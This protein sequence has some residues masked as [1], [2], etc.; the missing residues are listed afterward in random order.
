MSRLTDSALLLGAGILLASC[1]DSARVAGNSANTGNAQAA[2]R[3]VGPEGAPAPG[4]WIECRPDSL[5][6]WE[7]TQPGWSTL[8]DSSGSYLCSDLPAGRVGIAARDL[9]SG[10]TSWSADTAQVASSPKAKAPDT[11]APSGTLR[12]AL[13]PGSV[14]IL[15]LS[16]LGRSYAVRG[17]NE[18]ELSDIP[19]RWQ[20]SLFLA[21]SSSR[22]S[23][24]DSGLRVA[25]GRTDSAGYT[26]RSMT[27]RVSLGGKLASP[28]LQ[29]PLLARLD[30][31]WT[32][33]DQSLPDGSDLR[34]AT[35]SGRSLPTTVASWDRLART[36]AIWT[37][38]D[39]VAAPG[40]SVD[41]VLS[42]G[43]PVPASAPS[44][45]FSAAR[46]W[47]AA[48]PLG[49]TGAT[50]LERLGTF[51]GEA[52]STVSAPGPI[53]RS[54]RFDG[55]RSHVR[56]PGSATGALAPPDAGPY[57]WS[58]WVRLQDFG[59]SRFVMGRGENGSN[60]KFQRNF[61]PDSNSWMA[62][63]FRTTP[64]GGFY[65]LEPAD[66]GRWTH[67]AMTMSDTIVQLYVDGARSAFVP[68]FHPVPSGK[69][70]LP[71]LLGAAIDTLDGT[72]QHFLGDIAE[73]WAQNVARSPDWIRLVAANQKP[74]ASIV[75]PAR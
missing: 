54:S 56:I 57:T 69:K 61:G 29:F 13:P 59:T 60:L 67:L 5:A 36:G 6:P 71:L 45:A 70:D 27:V 48:W 50:A 42:W 10:L 28:V 21:R 1:D 37:L 12:V 41:L 73:A 30:S 44:P 66:T 22:S 26:R 32:G 19:A 15:Y 33:F 63:A 38:L 62:K 14:G 43:I 31:T 53:A 55:R 18:L 7:D 17:E 35:P 25:P 58:C 47:V 68:G 20:G 74:R 3:I 46:G 64:P 2:G 8:T 52:V 11:L 23:V 4:V 65:R 75:R 51:P 24:V 40:D 34:L 16:G 49:D 39:T 9:R 72:S